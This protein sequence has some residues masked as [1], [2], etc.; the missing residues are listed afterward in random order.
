MLN[1]KVDV[2]GYFDVCVPKQKCPFTSLK[3]RSASN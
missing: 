3:L 1:S 2:L